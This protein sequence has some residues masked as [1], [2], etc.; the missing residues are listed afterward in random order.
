MNGWL[1]WI[2]LK[3][4]LT[5]L[6]VMICAASALAVWRMRGI[7]QWQRSL[8]NEMLML[9]KSINNCS[10]AKS[11]AIRQILHHCSDI[12]QARS[13]NLN[14]ILRLDQ[15]LRSIAGCYYPDSDRPELSLT[16]GQTLTAVTQMVERLDKIIN[17]K[18]LR[19]FEHIRIRHIRKA[20]SWYTQIYHH[21][22]W[23]WML[24][25]KPVFDR[26]MHLK[27]CLIPD[28]FS[29]IA[30][31]SNKLTILILTRTLLIDIY[32]FVGRLAIEA[33]DPQ[34]INKY[35][36]PDND[37]LAEILAN[38]YDAEPVDEWQSDPKVSMIRSQLVG[39]P[40]KII[41]PPTMSEW[42]QAVLDVAQ[43]TAARHFNCSEAPLEEA[44]LG[45]MTVQ[46]QS[47]L[48][49]IG[50]VSHYSGIKHLFGIRLASIHNAHAF[51]T[52]LSGLPVAGV[53]KKAWGGYR[54]LR[55]PFKFYRWIKRS[56]PAGIAMELGVET[57]RKTL[58]NYLARI[59]FDRTCRELEILYRNSKASCH[60]SQSDSTLK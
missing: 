45:P 30:Y 25:H 48:R 12:R 18:G 6:A 20:V 50:D 47:L 1:F 51:A 53:A 10:E 7:L 57:I 32:L 33:Y 19:R 59:T 55:W 38:L 28:P 35:Y 21:S 27:R 43:I 2:Y 26:L 11:M 13:L 31:F 9:E 29:W 15:Y 37:R 44:A 34:T 3:A 39:I 58:I 54:T 42:R 4:G 22:V 24:E 16:L 56:S 23:G 40:K 14:I 60:H 17:R 49:S 8:S 36:A 52:S 41:M 46:L 5:I